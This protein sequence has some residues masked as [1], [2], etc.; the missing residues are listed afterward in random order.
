VVLDRCAKK[1]SW[2]SLEAYTSTIKALRGALENAGIE[3]TNG[4]RPGVRMRAIK[5]KR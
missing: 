3:F 5:R 4:E 2:S 1:I